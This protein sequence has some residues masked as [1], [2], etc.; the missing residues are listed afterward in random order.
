MTPQADKNTRATAALS[1]KKLGNLWITC[2][3]AG[4]AVDLITR[5]EKQ[6]ICTQYGC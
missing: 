2:I 5:N 4:E 6:N 3:T 1:K